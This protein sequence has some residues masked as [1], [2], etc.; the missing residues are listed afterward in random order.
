MRPIDPAELSGYLDG[1]LPAARAEEVRVALARDPVLRQSYEQLIALD[2]EW[3][4][5]AA[6]AVFQPRVRVHRSFIHGRFLVTA[7]AFGLFLLRLALKTAPPL[8]G[9]GVEAI[10]LLFLIGW[11]LRRIMRATDDDC[12]RPVLATDF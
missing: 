8:F 1:E 4:T 3:K 11:G 10:L 6:A 12:K 5:Q 9:A 2:A 7:A